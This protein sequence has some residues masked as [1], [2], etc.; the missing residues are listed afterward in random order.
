[1]K[2]RWFRGA[3]CILFLTSAL[4]GQSRDGLLKALNESPNWM[5]ADTAAEYDQSNI[6]SFAGRRAAA[7]QR[8]GV[9]GVTV[10]NW[11]GP[12]G[13]VRL[14]LYEMI[15]ATAAYGLF[16]LDRTADQPSA[17]SV[18]FGSEGYRVGSRMSF[19]QSKYVVRLDGSITA[20]SSIAP[21]ISENILGRSRKP[22]VS[23]MLPPN[24]LV[25]GTDRY[26]LA[27]EDIDSNLQ[28]DPSTLGLDDSAEIAIATY[29]I[30]NASARL[31]LILYPTQHV[32]KKYADAWAA[33]DPDNAPF[34]KRVGALIALVRDTRNEELAKQI[35]APVNYETQVTWNERLPDISLSTVILTIFSFIGLALL[36][37]VVAGISF[38]GLRV[39]VKSRYPN[40]VFDRAQDMEIIQL[41]LGQG[42]TRK[43]L[44]E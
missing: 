1:L 18:P 39:F 13:K 40:Q 38:G 24:N 35:L 6:E 5:P 34:R 21:I 20:M 30:D 11:S 42:F 19:W 10:Q 4:Q 8:Y 44:G 33:N 7:I 9:I 25:P 37:T 29:R 2:V 15:D 16:S 32:A 3:L 22:P 31:V 41:K 43:E 17:V 36:F 12:D 27:A 14:T 23:T 26:I 28:L